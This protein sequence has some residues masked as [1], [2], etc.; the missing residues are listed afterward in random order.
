M[1][2]TLGSDAAAAVF[3]KFDDYPWAKDRAFLVSH[4]LFRDSG[5]P[6]RPFWKRSCKQG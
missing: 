4:P 6:G 1:A 5:I 3:A 2:T